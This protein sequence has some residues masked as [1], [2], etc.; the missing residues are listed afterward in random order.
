MAF[1]SKPTDRRVRAQQ[2][3]EFVVSQVVEQAQRENVPLS[4]VERK[5][6]YFTE[7]EE[8]LP[9]IWEVNAQFENECDDAEYEKK[10]ASLLRKA[11]QRI[12]KESPE[13][14]RRWKQA[15]A[16]LRKEDYYL[17]V[18]VDQSLQPESDFWTVVAWASA[19]VVCLLAT[20]VLWVYL[21]EKGWIPSW[22]A[23]IPLKLAILGVFAVWFVVM[24]AKRGA[25]GDV[26]KALS[27]GV[28]DS[29]PFT[30]LR[31]RSRE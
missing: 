4:E 25:L 15:I 28:L 13:G 24:L 11:Y 31:K 1:A 5:M 19:I 16:D 21:D 29:F 12:R 30:L 26:I 3:K 20:I 9:D 27:L 22:I 23:S 6:L 2:A 8:T 14:E 17:L 7:T 10:I 18:M